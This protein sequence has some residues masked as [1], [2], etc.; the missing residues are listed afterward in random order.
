MQ[1]GLK[2]IV[3]AETAISFIDGNAGVLVYRGHPAA[4]V[5]VQHS[6]E[7]VAYLLWHGALPGA[8]ELSALQAEMRQAR[9]VPDFIYTLI[10]TLPQ[11]LDMMNQMAAAAT[12]LCPG[13][14]KPT[15]AQAVQL[16]AAM[17]VIAAAVYRKEQGLPAIR[18]HAALGH[19]AN[20]LYTLTGEVPQEAHARALEAYMILTMEHGLNASTFTA[21]VIASTESDMASAVSGAIGALK[22]PLHGG[23]PTEV[24]TMLE[25]IGTVERTE[26]WLRARLENGERLMGFG[27]RVYKTKD[28]RAVALRQ[29]TEQVGQDDHWLRLAAHV[30]QTAIRL[31][32][33]YKPGRG[34]YTN[35]E[36]YAAAVMRSIG[37]PASMFTPTFAVSRT[38]GWT[39]HVLE[40]AGDNTIFR[41]EARYT[42]VIYS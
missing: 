1:R 36:F 22:G 23:A 35:V 25:E 18:P 29:V 7:E 4:K 3:A 21:R 27:H 13:Q 31:L 41:P 38:V 33:E 30:E 40:Q 39:A 15:L 11:G 24:I 34:L 14:E 42:G 2:G 32:E 16:T 9:Q 6:F 5:A 28:P 8:A 20:Y 17:P 10:E 19:A 12:A 26:G 37:L